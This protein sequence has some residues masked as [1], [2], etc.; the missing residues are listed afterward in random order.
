MIGRISLALL[1]TLTLAG[2]S[3]PAVTVAYAGSLVTPMERQVGPAFETVCRCEFHGEGKG[4]VALA[5]LIAGGIKNPD[6]F[7]SA[8]TRVMDGLMRGSDPAIASYETF[9]SARMVLGYARRSRFAQRIALAAAHKITVVQ[10][11]ETPGLRIGRTDPRLDPKGK[12]SV[13]VVE[14]LAQRYHDRALQAIFGNEENPAQ[15]F[16]EEDLLVRLEAG[17]ID[18]AFLYS[19]EAIS[20]HVPAIEFP[21]QTNLEGSIRYAVAALRHARNREGGSAF[22]E[23]VLNG[24]GRAILE[25]AGLRYLKRPGNP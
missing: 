15:I 24:P 19:T 23:F 14:L 7:I 18:V 13:R 2:A 3:A 8:D 16:P 4:S 11:L 25:R 20:R 6:V 9:A 5:R 12:R 1:A 21:S 10:L 22:V 17:D